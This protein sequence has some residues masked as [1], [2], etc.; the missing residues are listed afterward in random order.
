MSARC[1]YVAKTVRVRD[2]KTYGMQGNSS[3]L[4]NR[5]LLPIVAVFR[6][7]VVLVV[8]VSD[9]N[10]ASHLRWICTVDA[11]ALFPTMQ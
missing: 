2:R 7:K 11:H 5:P 1:L 3:T 9:I 10:F 8:G 4:L 6:P